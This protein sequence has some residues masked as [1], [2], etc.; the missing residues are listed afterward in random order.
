MKYDYQTKLNEIN[1][2]IAEVKAMQNEL[3][4]QIL[5]DHSGGEGGMFGSV[6]GCNGTF[7]VE[8][9]YLDRRALHQSDKPDDEDVAMIRVNYPAFEADIEFDWLTL[10]E[11]HQ[12]IEGV[13]A[14]LREREQ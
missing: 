13:I 6:R 11:Q 14:E 3:M 5:Q 2:K 7:D 8:S 4:M 1:E 9:I 12:V 10:D